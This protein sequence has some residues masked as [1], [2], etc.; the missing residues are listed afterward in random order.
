MQRKLILMLEDDSDDR[1]ITEQ[2]IEELGLDV[3]I[4]FFS[5]SNQFLHF[6]AGTSLYPSLI[7][8]DYNSTPE[9]GLAVLKKIKA[10]TPLNKLP[11][12]IL[13]DSNTEKYK[14]EC[15]AHGASSFIQKPQTVEAT[16]NKI[17]TFFKYWFTVA[18]V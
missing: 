4:E 8:I 13:S 11:V 17:E 12:I 9:N 10:L 5:D 2:A 16:A 14:A 1:Y 15:Y 7:L 6:L 3:D 18:E